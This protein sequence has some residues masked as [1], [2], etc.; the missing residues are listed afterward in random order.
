MNGNLLFAGLEFGVWFTV[1]GGAH[2][3]QLDG[4]IPTAQARD[5]AIQR[6]ENDLVVG[7][8]GRGAYILDD[9]T[10]LRDVTPQALSEEGHLFP[11]RDAYMHDILGEVAATWGDPTTPNPPYGAVFTYSVGQSPAGESK[12]VLTITD[13]AGTQVRRLELAKEPGVHRIAWDLRGEVPPAA[14]GTAPAGRGGRGGDTLEAAQFF[15]RGRQGGPPAAAGRY[16]A[17]LGQLT[18]DTVTS[19]GQPQSFLVVALTR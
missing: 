2:W 3:V 12:L 14:P 9:Y 7:T 11:L 6:R 5:L 15:G 13:D 16:R 10:A 17:T 18:G 1:D 4:G 8:F 19:I